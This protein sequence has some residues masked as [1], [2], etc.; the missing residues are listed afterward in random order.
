MKKILLF[1]LFITLGLNLVACGK[2]DSNS[3]QPSEPTKHS[4]V[5]SEEWTYDESNHWHQCECGEGEKT[6][7]GRHMYESEITTYPTYDSEGVTT[8]TCRCGYSYEES[9]P[10]LESVDITGITFESASFEYTG[11]EIYLECDNIP[12]DVWVDYE[13]NGQVEIGEYE[14]T[15][16]IYD[17]LDNELG[18]LTATLTITEAEEKTPTEGGGSEDGEIDLSNVIFVDQTLQYTG[19]HVAVAVRN[20][21]AEG[22]E[23][24][25]TYELDGVVL[26]EMIEV[27]VYTVKATIK[28]VVTKEELLVLTATIT[29]TDEEVYDEI[30]N[31]ANSKIELTYTTHFIQMFKNPDDP[32]QLI[33]SRIDIW[34]KETMLFVLDR[35]TTLGAYNEPLKFFNLDP[36]S[37]ECASLNG[38][39]LT[40]SEAGVYDVI[41]IFPEGEIVPTLLVR[42]SGEE[43]QTLYFISNVFNNE[44]NEQSALAVNNKGIASIELDLAVGDVFRIATYYS[45]ISYN[46]DQYFNLM[47]QFR[48]GNEAGSVEVAVAGR[49][50]FLVKAETLQIAIYLDGVQVEADPNMLFMRGTVTDPAWDSLSLPVYKTNGIASIEIDLEVGHT[51]KIANSDWTSIYDYGFFSSASSYFGNDQDNNIVVKQAGTYKIEINV[52]DNGKTTVYY[53]GTKIIDNATHNGGGNGGGGQAG[54]VMYQIVI[55][56]ETKIDLIYEG[57]WDMDNSYDQ[58]HAFSVSLQAGDIITFLNVSN[59]ETWTDMAV[60]GASHGGMT[61]ISG[62]G[63]KVGTTGVYDLYVKTKFQADNIYFGP[64]ASH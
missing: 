4:H 7:V 45:S 57:K 15:A 2:D 27:G 51:F 22:V 10:M 28:D 33:A 50:K 29:I 37:I 34:A 23:V 62:T 20:L 59:G 64:A 61:L 60:D 21:P 8:Y 44:Y 16:I 46:Y 19:T 55:N 48:P 32:T 38:Y 11:G 31:D 58:H 26:K 49:Y 12:D 43:D 35:D 6:S 30:P 9:I 24:H 42:E 1:L 54:T 52:N 13:G 53:N 25:Y 41:M 56:G 3:S 5:Q 36:N 63:I 39:E 40:I 18:R 14:V 47:S 17:M